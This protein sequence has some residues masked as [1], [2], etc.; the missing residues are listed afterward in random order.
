MP[1]YLHR[2]AAQH[3]NNPV[4]TFF[5]GTRATFVDF[6]AVSTGKFRAGIEPVSFATQA[7]A[8]AVAVVLRGRCLIVEYNETRGGGNKLTAV[9]RVAASIDVEPPAKP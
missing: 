7:E 3:N 4:L 2:H 6:D 1:F 9:S 5:D 8:A